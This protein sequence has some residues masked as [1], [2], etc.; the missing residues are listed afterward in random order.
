MVE[1]ALRASVIV[2][3]YNAARTLECCLAALLNQSLPRQDYEVILVDDGSSDETASIAARFPSVRLIKSL[4]RGAA[5]ARNRGAREACG[6]VLLFTDADCEPA[7]DWVHQM[8]TPFENSQ[9]CL[10]GCKGVYRTSQRGLVPR[11]VQIEYEEKYERMSRAAKIDFVDTYSAAYDRQIFLTSGGFD[12]SFPSASVEDQEFSFRLA[13]QGR[14]LVFNPR[15]VVY[16]QHPTT[17][18]AYVRRKFKIGYWKVHLHRRHPRKIWRDSH[19]PA[20]LKLQVGLIPSILLAATAAFFAPPA[21]WIVVALVAMLVASILPLTFFAGRRD[22]PVMWIVPAMVIIRA[23]ALAFG[24]AV[25]IG[26]QVSRS[27]HLKRGLDI[28][29][30][31]VGLVIFAPL[32]LL[33]A[34]AIKLDSPGPVFFAQLRGGKD[35][36][37]FRMFKFRSMVNGAEEMLETVISQNCLPPPVFK[38]PNDPRV[39][40]V[41]R[42]CRRY[43]LDELPQF[44]NVLRGEMSLIG[45]RPEEMRIIAQYDAFQ[46]RRLAA[47]PGMTGPM[48]TDGRGTLTLDERVRIELAYIDSYSI[49][50]DFYYLLKTLPAVLRGRGSY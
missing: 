36:K 47:K 32:M 2:P 45:P 23:G 38:I 46:K 5:A 7:Q 20:S 25:G 22:R 9:G 15:A 37:P 34:I 11:F 29:G 13:S 8:L 28:V 14:L 27:S 1:Q 21:W 35:G 39:T 43:S 30:A 48:Q 49:W 50:L 41:G 3:A 19:T 4:H 16:H 26:S 40:R 10:V 6:P 24:L 12:E 18:F 42:F 33:L 31:V 44:V 17:L